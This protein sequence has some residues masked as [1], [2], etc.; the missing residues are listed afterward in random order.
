[1]KKSFVE[2]YHVPSSPFSS[3]A[4]LKCTRCMVIQKVSMFWKK[5]FQKLRNIKIN[6]NP[7]RRQLHIVIAKPAYK[8]TNT[9]TRGRAKGGLAIIM[10]KHVRKHIK[11]IECDSWRI[12][13]LLLTIKL[14]K[15]LIINVY[16][17]T[18]PK[19]INGECN[20]LEDCLARLSSLIN[21]ND[22]HHLQIAGD[23]NFEVNRNTRHSLKIKEFMME[24]KLFSLW[25]NHEVDFTHSFTN[26]NHETFVHI[27]DHFLI[28]ERSEKF[29]L[30]AG[31]IHNV[32]NISDHEPMF[33]VIEVPQH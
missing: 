20:E 7:E 17:P 12:Q 23:L 32:D 27:L 15:V 29:V 31:I 2:E 5:N 14:K 1:M 24:N 4:V 26:E 33:S 3:S 21:G 6:M 30:E 25:R 18:D 10:P 19:T 9:Q 28:L 13:P 16:F 22:F 11:I 8:D